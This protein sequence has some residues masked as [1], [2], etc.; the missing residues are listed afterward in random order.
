MSTP[1]ANC[2]PVKP[3]NEPIPARLTDL[4]RERVSVSVLNLCRTWMGVKVRDRFTIN[5]PVL[6]ECDG[7]LVVG[8]V[9]H[10]MK[11]AKG[12]YVLGVAIG[13]IVDMA[14]HRS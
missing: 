14:Y 11:T 13:K 4:Y 2:R 10:C 1:I 9:R 8:T 3:R 5:F 6:V 12:G 7:L